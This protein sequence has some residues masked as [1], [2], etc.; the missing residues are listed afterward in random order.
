MAL[1]YGQSVG[2]LAQNEMT[3]S[4]QQRAAAERQ[5]ML[6]I[7]QLQQRRENQRTDRVDQENSDNLAW[8]RRFREQTA[9]TQRDQFDRQMAQTG[10]YYDW[11]MKQP[12]AGV[13]RD[14]IAM[15]TAEAD[16]GLFSAPEEVQSRYPSLTPEI[17]GFM[18]RRSLFTRQQV[19]AE[20][21]RLGQEANTL[22]APTRYRN[23]ITADQAVERPPGFMGRLFGKKADPNKWYSTPE[24]VAGWT[25]AEAEARSAAEPLRSNKDI[26]GR[27]TVDENGMYQPRVSMPWRSGAGAGPGRLAGGALQNKIKE[28]YQAITAGKDPEAVRQYVLKTYGVDINQYRE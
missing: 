20:A 28:A 16:E 13:N 27:M 8:T 7:Q 14:T 3:L 24:D 9:S 10:K 15:A 6:L 23:M 18:A 5:A 21:A 2:Q 4:A 1:P 26:M 17:A 22:N 19:E 25:S 11:Q 12:N